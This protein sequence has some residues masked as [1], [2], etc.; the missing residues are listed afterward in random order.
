MEFVLKYGTVALVILGA[1]ITALAAVA[2]L[3]KSDTDNKALAF[4]Q[5]VQAFV[6][7]LIAP[8][9]VVAKSTK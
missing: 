3:T 8:N 2:P 1:L 7:R 9:A 5:K 4:L 6:A